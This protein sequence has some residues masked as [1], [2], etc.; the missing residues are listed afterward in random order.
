MLEGIVDTN[1][2]GKPDRVSP[3]SDADGIPDRIEGSADA[4]KDKTANYRDLDSD[5][6]NIPDA[7][8]GAYD[9]DADG[10]KDSPTPTTTRTDPRL[11]RGG[12]SAVR[13][14]D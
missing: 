11:H 9:S 14:P 6:D 4:D 2:D 12:R 5:G 7:V 8:E 1:N 10:I 3:D 13:V